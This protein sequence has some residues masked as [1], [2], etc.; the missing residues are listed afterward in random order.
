MEGG[1]GGWE[2]PCIHYNLELYYH[3]FISDDKG[4]LTFM[5]RKTESY[6]S[7]VALPKSLFSEEKKREIIVSKASYHE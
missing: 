4:N 1:G 6:M 5:R 7:F 2:V 3:S